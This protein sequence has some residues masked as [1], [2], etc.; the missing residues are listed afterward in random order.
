MDGCP[1]DKI[2][3]YPKDCRQRINCLGTLGIE[4]LAHPPYSPDIAPYDFY[5]FPKIKE[6]LQGKWFTDA[7]E[8]VA[9]YDKGVEATLKCE[10]TKCFSQ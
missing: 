9:A 10:W 1:L 7:E 5:L 3:S 6:T 8:A 4:I 2:P